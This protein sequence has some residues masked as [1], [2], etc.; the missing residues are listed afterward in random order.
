MS[1]Y[2][3]WNSVL[4]LIHNL[5]T[6]CEQT[7]Y[8]QICYEISCEWL[9]R[10]EYW[11][12]GRWFS[13][14]SQYLTC[15]TTWC[16]IHNFLRTEYYQLNVFLFFRGPTIIV[17][18]VRPHFSSFFNIWSYASRSVLR[19]PFPKGNAIKKIFEIK[20]K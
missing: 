18:T 15:C 7:I 3:W 13:Q 17:S 16:A 9:L 20:T 5:K 10:S 6:Q 14:R 2:C 12:L 8:V 19:F 11:K 4:N 1:T